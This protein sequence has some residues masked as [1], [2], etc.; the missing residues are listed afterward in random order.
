MPTLLIEHGFKFFF[1]ANEH[2]PM[3]IHVLKAE[4]FAKINLITLEVVNNYVKPASLKKAIVIARLHKNEFRR[5]W[6]EYFNKR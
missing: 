2:D 6:N 3:H 5:A 4:E 1:Y